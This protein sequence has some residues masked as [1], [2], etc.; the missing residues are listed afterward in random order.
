MWLF[1]TENRTLFL[2]NSVLDGG[3]DSNLKATQQPSGALR[4]SRLRLT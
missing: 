4:G 2:R 1:F 3:A